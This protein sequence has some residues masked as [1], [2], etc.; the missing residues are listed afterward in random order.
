MWGSG[1]R[2]A[3]MRVTRARRPTV[4]PGRVVIVTIAWCA[5][6]PGATVR[7]A[8]FRRTRRERPL[9]P[10]LRYR[11][12]SGPGPVGRRRHARSSEQNPLSG[13]PLCCSLVPFSAR[14]FAPGRDFLR[15]APM[16]PPGDN[17]THPYNR[18]HG[19]QCR[20]TVRSYICHSK[21]LLCPTFFRYS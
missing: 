13:F 8:A 17:T 9:V 2:I 12:S 10:Q 19:I 11:L 3:G 5:A 4:A 16:Q 15:S 21:A 14:R 18:W 20:P 6:G 1:C 7:G